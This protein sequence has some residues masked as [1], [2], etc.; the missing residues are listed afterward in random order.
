[1]QIDELPSNIWDDYWEQSEKTHRKLLMGICQKNNKLISELFNKKLNHVPI[2]IN[3]KSFDNWTPIHFASLHGNNFAL[4]ILLESPEI[5]VNSL[6]N[7]K[8]S[9][10][11]VATKNN[12]ADS[13]SL[14]IKAGIDCNIQDED[15]NTALHYAAELGHKEIV[16]ILLAVE[17]INTNLRN[18]KGLTAKEM[19]TSND[20][21]KIF[22]SSDKSS[23]QSGFFTNLKSNRQI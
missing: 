22:N 11:H 19:T 10:L 7:F 5:Y 4:E 8:L 12:K 23:S 16:T 13:V 1:M 21:M 3:F 9:A 20:I 14:L 15:G 2:N 17:K 18:N 6:T